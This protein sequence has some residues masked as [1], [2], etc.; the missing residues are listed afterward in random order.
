M[1]R[2]ERRKSAPT[3]SAIWANEVRFTANI[4][5][6]KL[7]E[8]ADTSMAYAAKRY[9]LPWQISALLAKLGGMLS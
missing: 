5:T 1:S 8:T 3:A 9:C 2:L 6:A 4:P 7:S